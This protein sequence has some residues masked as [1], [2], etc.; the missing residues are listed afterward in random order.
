MASF[1]RKPRIR[2]I[3]YHMMIL[4]IQYMYIIALI[5]FNVTIEAMLKLHVYNSCI[6]HTF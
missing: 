1:I 5:S 3:Q 2:R 6:V 4:Q